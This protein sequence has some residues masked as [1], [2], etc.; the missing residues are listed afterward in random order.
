MSKGAKR[1]AQE[2]IADRVKTLTADLSTALAGDSPTTVQLATEL[3]PEL[4]SL[5]ATIS[6]RTPR[7]PPPRGPPSTNNDENNGGSKPDK[8]NDA[9]KPPVK[10]PKTEDKPF[11]DRLEGLQRAIAQPPIAITEYETFWKTQVNYSSSEA[12]A[13]IEDA[14]IARLFR[15]CEMTAETEDET[16]DLWLQAMKK[17]NIAPTSIR[18]A[19]QQTEA[20]DKKDIFKWLVQTHTHLEKHEHSTQATNFVNRI[21]LV[22]SALAFA[23]EYES[24]S[25]HAKKL[26]TQS[27]FIA[28]D[29]ALRFQDVALE[30]ASK[31]ID[32]EMADEFRRWKKKFLRNTITPRK[33]LESTFFL[34]RFGHPHHIDGKRSTEFTRLLEALYDEAPSDTRNMPLTVARYEGNRAATL[35]V[36][37]AFDPQLARF[38]RETF[39][40][41]T[42]NAAATRGYIRGQEELAA[43]NNDEEEDEGSE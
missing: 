27:L 7:A 1:K 29:H 3:K 35:G 21:Y 37:S 12:R 14:A 31:T 43:K 22:L 38:A 9:K 8:D 13:T 2:N 23:H 16:L 17:Y 42:T 10:K 25:D 41:C 18:R 4:D 11:H 24:L 40:S 36:I 19:I 26:A 15:G 34:T 28:Q 39:T 33:K 30:T 6:A 32:N 20:L 5:Y